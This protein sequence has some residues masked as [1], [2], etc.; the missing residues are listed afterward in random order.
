MKP[1]Q[2]PTPPNTYKKPFLG[3]LVILAFAFLIAF[4]LSLITYYL[5]NKE[6]KIVQIQ[7]LTTPSEKPPLLLKNIGVNLDYYDSKT[8]KAGG[9]LFTTKKLQFDRLFMGFGFVIPA[10][11]SSSGKDKS[12]PQPTFV[13]P[14]GTPVKSMVDGIVAAMPTLWSGDISIQVT[15]DGKMQKWI[16]ET[17]HVRNPKV[18]VGDRVAAGQVIAEVGNFGN[19]APSGFGLVE[20][21]ILKG[22]QKPQHVCPF[23]YLDFSIKE[24]V[25]SKIRAF[26]TSWEEYKKDT[27]LYNEKIETIPGCLTLNSIEG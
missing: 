23:A 3:A 26:Y 27:T 22:G 5:L 17:E 20:I 7:P 15:A 21:G 13:V 25:F 4:L 10:H 14:L 18:K 16:Y 8:N 24:E 11:T 12:N 9:F 19:N 1:V 6:Q 2:T